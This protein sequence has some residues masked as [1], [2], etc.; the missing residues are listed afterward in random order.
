MNKLVSKLTAFYLLIVMV[1]AQDFVLMCFF[2]FSKGM[3]F[4]LVIKK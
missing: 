3:V 2:F 4:L 1:I